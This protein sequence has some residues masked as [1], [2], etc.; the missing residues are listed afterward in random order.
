MEIGVINPD[1]LFQIL[2]KDKDWLKGAALFQFWVE[3]VHGNL[4]EIIRN[5]WLLPQLGSW[6]TVV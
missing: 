4:S 6:E 5:N 3:V 2:S 1:L